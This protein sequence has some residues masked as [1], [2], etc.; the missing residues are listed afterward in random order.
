MENHNEQPDWENSA[1]IGHDIESM[2]VNQVMQFYHRCLLESP[3]ALDYLV[4]T[5]GI[6]LEAINTFKVG[7][8]D[9]SLGNHIPSGDLASGALLRGALRRKGLL[10]ENGRERFRGC[11]V[12]PI[13]EP[14]GCLSNVYGRIISSR[15]RK[16]GTPYTVISSGSSDF[17]NIGALD[18]FERIALCSSPIEALTFWTKG[19]YNVVSTT[20]LTHFNCHHA[21]YIGES[22]VKHVDIVFTNS[23]AGNRKSYLIA[24]DLAL[25]GIKTNIVKLPRGRD[26]NDLHR[27]SLMLDR[28]LPVVSYPNNQLVH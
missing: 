15:V 28:I 2:H 26:I 16:G 8:V 14:L 27:Y 18:K 25:F 1:L 5:R 12:V 13:Y 17:F 19:V 4:S 9:R 22:F 7:F 3:K 24:Q 11:V 10:K 20:G 23:S 6:S 21:E